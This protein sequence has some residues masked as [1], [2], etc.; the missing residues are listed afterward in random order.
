[1]QLTCKFTTIQKLVTD[2]KT[3]KENKISK[4]SILCMIK[5]LSS[6]EAHHMNAET[7]RG[8]GEALYKKEL[9]ESIF[10]KK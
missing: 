7:K 10:G 6:D 2:L 3:V 9:K 8:K 4:F 1:M 5:L